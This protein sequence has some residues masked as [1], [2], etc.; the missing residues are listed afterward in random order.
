MPLSAIHFE[1]AAI[2]CYWRRVI[3]RYFLH[4]HDDIE[5][6]I[7]QPFNITRMYC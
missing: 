4:D 5:L 6:C 7:Q 2:L 1:N 3:I